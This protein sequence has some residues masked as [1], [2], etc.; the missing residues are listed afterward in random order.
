[1]YWNVIF[2]LDSLMYIYVII[3]NLGTSNPTL[4]QH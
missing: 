2:I 1:M 3:L 4:M